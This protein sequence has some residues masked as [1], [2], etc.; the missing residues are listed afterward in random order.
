LPFRSLGG[1]DIIL[2]RIDYQNRPRQLV[3][4]SGKVP[5]HDRTFH[6]PLQP[7]QKI[8]AC[9]QV[10]K[11]PRRSFGCVPVC[12]EWG[13]RFRP[14]PARVAPDGPDIVLRSR[15]KV[16][17]VHGCFW[18]MHTCRHGFGKTRLPMLNSGNKKR[19]GNVRSATARKPAGIAKTRMEHSDDLGMLDCG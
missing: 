9:D 16:I 4:R 1:F 3:G 13:F 17:F 8:W 5:R 10:E 15:M 14:S 6:T 19:S 18:H 7:Q 12:I 2:P 11:T